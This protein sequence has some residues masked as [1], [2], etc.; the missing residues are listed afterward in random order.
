MKYVEF[1]QQ[2]DCLEVQLPEGLRHVRK[3]LEKELLL[4]FVGEPE[5]YRTAERM[6]M[7]VGNW[8]V[9]NTKS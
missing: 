1:D 5:N 9:K 3:R 8:L 7:F 4:N 6:D 2:T